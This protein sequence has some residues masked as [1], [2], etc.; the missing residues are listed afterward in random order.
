MRKEENFDAV[1]S[2]HVQ[3]DLLIMSGT[4]EKC[5]DVTLKTEV[6][7]DTAPS[8]RD[9]KVCLFERCLYFFKLIN[10]LNYIIYNTFSNIFNSCEAFL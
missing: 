4:I 6:V 3:S 5:G 7:E 9:P 10:I 2:L 8:R 1:S